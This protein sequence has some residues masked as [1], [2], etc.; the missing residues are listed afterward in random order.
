M[1]T[2]AMF[3]YA[4]RRILFWLQILYIYSL[5]VKNDWEV[6]GEGGLLKFFDLSNKQTNSSSFLSVNIF[7]T[8][9]RTLDET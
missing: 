3:S 1:Y 4:H 7:L 2:R 9:V 5:K 6:P 8:G